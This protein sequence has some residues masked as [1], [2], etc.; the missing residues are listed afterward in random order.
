MGSNPSNHVLP[1]CSR[2]LL[3]VHLAVLDR[4]EQFG[5]DA[6]RDTCFLSPSRVAF[7]TIIFQ[8]AEE[9]SAHLLRRWAHEHLRCWRY[10]AASQAKWAY[11]RLEETWTRV[12]TELDP[13][14]PLAN[15]VKPLFSTPGRKPSSQV[16]LRQQDPPT[17]F[18]FCQW[19]RCSATMGCPCFLCAPTATPALQRQNARWHNSSPIRPHLYS[20]CVRWQ[21]ACIANLYSPVPAVFKDNNYF[22]SAHLKHLK[23]NTLPDIFGPL[24]IPTKKTICH[25]SYT[26]L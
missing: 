21:V 23:I 24:C 12:F 16:F 14:S 8:N 7:P 3:S 11:I 6:K 18:C 15:W 9:I 13:L 5:T 22:S 20:E 26:P 19:V 10:W 1:L 2:W 17:C 4:F 25:I